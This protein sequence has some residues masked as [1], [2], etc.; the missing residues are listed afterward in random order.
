MTQRINERERRLN[1]SK[2]GIHRIKICCIRGKD[3]L[4]RR[5]DEFTKAKEDFIRGKEVFIEE[6]AERERAIQKLE[7]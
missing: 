6:R 3:E 1:P 2:E 4:M 5:N 7:G